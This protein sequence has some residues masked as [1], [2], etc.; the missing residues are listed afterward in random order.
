MRADI[1]GGLLWFDDD[2]RRPIQEK[3]AEAAQRYRERVGYEPTVCQLNP[4]Q[5]N[6]LVAGNTPGV[7]R[8]KR[9]SASAKVVAPPVT[10]RLVPS[11]LI[12]PH[13]YL[14]TIGEGEEPKPAT[15]PYRDEDEPRQVKVAVAERASRAY[16]LGRA[17]RAKSAAARPVERP[18][19]VPTPAATAPSARKATTKAAAAAAAAVTATPATTKA[20]TVRA[21][22]AKHETPKDNAPKLATTKGV[23]PKKASER[24][25]KVSP[26]GKAIK[27]KPA[28]V[29]AVPATPTKARAAEKA[30]RL[31]VVEQ[32]TLIAAAPEKP[33][34][35]KKTKAA[36]AIA[37]PEATPVLA[38]ATATR[39]APARVG[40]KKSTSASTPAFQAPLLPLVEA[41]APRMRRP[42]KHVA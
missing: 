15:L 29:V 8:A 4:A 1:A 2:A 28:A 3:I 16:P 34:R 17:P 13:C 5:A 41:E 40:T 35:A 32:P 22:T 30:T 12:Q 14:I 18:V 36:S 11:D 24:V 25:K 42:R 38:A 26:A 37:A 19:A 31:P 20:A 6:A 9:A 27:P 7:A 21:A 39:R 10:L 33:T 23:T